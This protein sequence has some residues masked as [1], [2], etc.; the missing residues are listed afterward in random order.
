MQRKVIAPALLAVLFCGTMLTVGCSKKN[1]APVFS[2][3]TATPSDSVLMPSSVVTLKVA[4]TDEDNDSLTFTWSKSAGT[5]PVTYGDSAVWTAPN[6]AQVCTVSV[7]CSDGTADID[8]SHVVR[9]RAWLSGDLDGFTPD[10]TYLPN[11]GTTEIPFTWDVDDPFPPGAKVDSMLLTMTFDDSDSLEMEQFN[12]YLVSPAGTEVLL[13][14]GV[15]LT[16]LD[17]E[18]Y[19]VPG[20]AGEV[21]TGTWELKFVRNNPTGRNGVVESCDL[22]MTYKY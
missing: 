10:S 2:S 9:V 6:A 17:L 22:D 7:K 4:A 8:T 15:E 5:M 1:T 11:V 13:Y 12:V 19:A 18:Q 21:V 16:T 14:D 20:F 3:F